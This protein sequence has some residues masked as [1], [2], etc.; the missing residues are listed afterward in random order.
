MAS[1]QANETSPQCKES[2]LPAPKGRV[3]ISILIKAVFST[4]TQG[5]IRIHT[6]IHACTHARTHA[7]THSRTHARMRA[8][9]HTHI[10]RHNSQKFPSAFI[11]CPSSSPCW[12]CS[13]GWREKKTNT[14]KLRL[15]QPEVFFILW[16]AKPLYFGHRT[17]CRS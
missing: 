3:P 9:T 17:V 2:V 5:H 13:R 1:S 8:H 12:C 6:Y 15:Q 14:T 4:K 7:L 16:Y 11:H 10:Y